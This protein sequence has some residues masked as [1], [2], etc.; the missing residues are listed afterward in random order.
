MEI[1]T[2]EKLISTHRFLGI[3]PF[4]HPKKSPFSGIDNAIFVS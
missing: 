4:C 2:N 3:A 1:Q